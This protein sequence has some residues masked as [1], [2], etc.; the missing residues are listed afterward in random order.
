M[1]GILRYE[2]NSLRL[3]DIRYA[4]APFAQIEV[5]GVFGY[6]SYKGAVR[7]MPGSLMNFYVLSLESRFSGVA[8]YID[9]LVCDSVLG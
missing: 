6:P 7:D 5:T 4:L 8:P 1:R 9:V 3:S 2:V